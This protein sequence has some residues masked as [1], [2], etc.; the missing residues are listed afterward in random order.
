VNLLVLREYAARFVVA[1]A[2][3]RF[4]QFDVMQP[5]TEQA[6]VIDAELTQARPF[7]ARTSLIIVCAE[8][9][10]LVEISAPSIEQDLKAATTEGFAVLPAGVLSVVADAFAQPPLSEELTT[11]E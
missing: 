2:G 8:R 4:A 5:L 7:T 1:A 11:Y 10:C 3:Q 6:L 9:D